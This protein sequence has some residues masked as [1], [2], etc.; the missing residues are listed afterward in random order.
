MKYAMGL[1]ALLVVGGAST[2]WAECPP[3]TFLKKI[4]TVATGTNA[5]GSTDITTAGA[6]VRMSVVSCAGTACVATLYDADAAD[7]NNVDGTVTLEPGAPA[8]TSV[9]QTYDPPISFSSGITMKDD[10]NVNAVLLYGCS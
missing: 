1:V 2:A 4:G 3:G 6:Q 8:S 7:S 9:T 5:I 10:G